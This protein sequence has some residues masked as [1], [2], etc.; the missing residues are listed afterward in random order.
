MNLFTAIEKRHSYRGEFQ[1]ATVPEEHLRQIVQAGISA[2]SGCNAQATFF[3]IV[4]EKQQMEELRR[5]I[6]K[7]VM[8]TAPAAIVV[9]SE[10]RI[11]SE[12]LSFEKEDYAAAVENMLL[13]ITALGYASVWLDGVLRNERRA[14]RIAEV[15]GI[16][17]IYTVDVVLPIGIPVEVRSQIIKKP[18]EE[19]AWFN[20]FSG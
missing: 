3:L 10:N 16:P 2:P 4:N 7:P 15:L 18:F 12:G 19:R 20:R 13:A 17:S 6:A 5:I 14:E 8:Q 11:V 1:P 9:F